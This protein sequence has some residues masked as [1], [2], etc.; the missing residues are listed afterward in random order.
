MRRNIAN[1]IKSLKTGVKVNSIY[2]VQKVPNPTTSMLVFHKALR[3]NKYITLQADTSLLD[4]LIPRDELELIISKIAAE[5]KVTFEQ[6]LHT[7]GEFMNNIS[8]FLI[9]VLLPMPLV[10]GNIMGDIGILLGLLIYLLLIA[11][12][13][14]SGQFL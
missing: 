14:F 12:C 7:L 11:L 3:G 9:I 13:L 5:G 2:G 1:L 6:G 10:F 8:S 4:N